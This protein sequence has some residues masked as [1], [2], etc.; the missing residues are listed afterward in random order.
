MP[1]TTIYQ[2]CTWIFTIFMLCVIYVYWY[3]TCTV[4]VN[5]HIY[6]KQDDLTWFL[7]HKKTFTILYYVSQPAY[8]G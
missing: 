7:I 6:E 3:I 1:K 5:M 8:L 2:E 4:I